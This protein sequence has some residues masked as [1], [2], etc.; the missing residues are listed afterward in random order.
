MNAHTLRHVHK[1]SPGVSVEYDNLAWFQG[2]MGQIL[3]QGEYLLVQLRTA[4]HNSHAPRLKAGRRSA[5]GGRLVAY[6]IPSLVL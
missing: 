5:G 2:M 3:R 6:H 1:H 4:G